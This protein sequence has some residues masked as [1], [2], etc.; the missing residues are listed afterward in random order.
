[1]GRTTVEVLDLD[2]GLDLAVPHARPHDELQCSQKYLGF[3]LKLQKIGTVCMY[4]YLYVYVYGSNYPQWKGC[5]LEIP[6][7][8]QFFVAS[9]LTNP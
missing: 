9:C 4:T 5:L 3:F 8:T 2:V 6:L 1:M 7:Q